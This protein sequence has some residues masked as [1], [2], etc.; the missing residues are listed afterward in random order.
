MI[1]V[2]KPPMGA[3]YFGELECDDCGRRLGFHEH[4]IRYKDF[5]SYD[6]DLK[7][8]VRCLCKHWHDVTYNI[9]LVV[10]QH[11]R[12]RP[13]REAI[14]CWWRRRHPTTKDAIVEVANNEPVWP[15]G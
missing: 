5:G 8:A 13:W 9:P 2:R 6:T 11:V 12:N 7:F 4:D 15:E 3:P 10:R 1:E 14:R